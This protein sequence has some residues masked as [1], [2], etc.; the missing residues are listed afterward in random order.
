MT[1]IDATHD[2]ASQHVP[3]GGDPAANPL[4][5]ARGYSPVVVAWHDRA[6]PLTEQYRQLRTSLLAQYPNDKFSLLVTSAEPGEG[7]T[8]T[9]VNMGFVLAE[10]YERNVLIVDCNLRNGGVAAMLGLKSAPGLTEVLRCTHPL[11]AVVQPTVCA[12]LSV[13]TAGAATGEDVANLLGGPK[14]TE[15]LQE[16]QR[17][18]DYVLLD[19]TSVSMVSDVGTLGRL[20]CEALMVVR[21]NRTRRETV[22]R[23]IR[24]LQVVNV[25]LAGMVLTHQKFYI[26]GFLY[27]RL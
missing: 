2:Q 24:M 12:N 3:S 27:N 14:M 26:P 4:A 15:T 13:I 17:R 16:L 22:N 25:R 8:V 10:R 1:E 9:C 6:G 23:A 11:E 7:K 18:Y 19:T 5:Q 21:M 20:G